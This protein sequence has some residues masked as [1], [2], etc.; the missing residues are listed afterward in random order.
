MFILV[1][2]QCGQC[3]PT[4]VGSRSRRAIRGREADDEG[5][6]GEE[7]KEEEEEEEGDEEGEG[8]DKGQ[9]LKRY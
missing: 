1:T 8:D 4:S 5:A 6:G 7:D 3:T 9:R 2:Q